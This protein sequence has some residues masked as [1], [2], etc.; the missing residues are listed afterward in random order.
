MLYDGYTK[1]TYKTLQ[2]IKDINI[3]SIS[4]SRA[5]LRSAIDDILNILSLSS[6]EK[7]KKS[8]GFDEFFHLYM[9]IHL[10]ND[11]YIIV[12]KSINIYLY[13]IDK[14][15][16]YLQNE[17]KQVSQI[18]I[19][20]VGQLLQTTKNIMG[21][22][23]LKYDAF[24][25]NCQD[26]LIN[27]LTANNMINKDLETFIKQDVEEL[28]QDLPNWTQKLGLAITNLIGYIDKM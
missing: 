8:H 12:E 21:D 1:K 19:I 15:S 18:P 25:N 5:P 28:A 7:L 3:K 4:I 27:I 14:N 16:A 9:I 20:T 6:W 13:T 22:R 11:E 26:F 2:R 17:Q 23:Y 10:E 24:Q